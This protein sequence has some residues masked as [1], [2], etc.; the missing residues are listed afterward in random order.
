LLSV[1]N[2]GPRRFAI[3]PPCCSSNMLPSILPFGSHMWRSNL[4][5]PFHSLLNSQ[6][7]SQIYPG[8]FIRNS[9]K[10]AK[11]GNPRWTAER[12]SDAVQPVQQPLKCQRPL[13]VPCEPTNQQAE[14]I[15][16]AARLKAALQIGGRRSGQ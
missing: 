6:G 3:F 8:S 15:A 10:I 14:I 13:P 2:F 16:A 12:Y 9:A 1:V 7:P 5:F 11:S 4:R